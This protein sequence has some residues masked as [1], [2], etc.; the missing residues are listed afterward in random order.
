M[1]RSRGIELSFVPGDHLYDEGDVYKIRFL[2][3]DD[4][5]VGPHTPGQ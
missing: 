2:V 4:D 5:P 3:A 1:L